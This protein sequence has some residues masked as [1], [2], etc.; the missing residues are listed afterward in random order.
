MVEE[1]SEDD[2]VV[3]NENVKAID[4]PLQAAQQAPEPFE[5]DSGDTVKEYF[6]AIGRHPLLTATQEVELGLAVEKWIR[7]KETRNEFDETYHRP[8]SSEELAT[9]IYRE[10]RG[11][12]DVVVALAK[13]LHEETKNASLADLLL[14]PGRGGH[15]HPS[16]FPSERTSRR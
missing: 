8:A 2:E 9:A 11:R 15:L 16:P 12:S 4:K 10:I 6:R 5:E 7:L 13:S 3:Q 1:R 14:L